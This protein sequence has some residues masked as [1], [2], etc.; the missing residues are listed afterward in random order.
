MKQLNYVNSRP[1]GFEHE[2]IVNIPLFSENMN[3]IFRQSDSTYLNRLQIFRNAVEGQ[4]GVMSTALSS[5]APGV[6]VTYRGVVPEGF[7]RRIISLSPIQLLTMISSR[8]MM[9]ALVAGRAFSKDFGTDA[10]EGFMVNETAVRDF[11]WGTPE[12]ALGKTLTREGKKGHVIGVIRDFN[13]SSLTTAITPMVLE[14]EP[15]QLNTL[16]VR[17]DNPDVKESIEKLEASW[18]KIFPEKSFEFT[19]LD[20]QL[21]EQYENFQNFG[22]VIQS[23]TLIAILISCLG[24]YGLVLFV[25]QRKVKE[26]GVR[27]VLGAS[28]GNI[29]TLIYKDFAWLLAIG[30]VLAVPVSYYL[31]NRWLENFIYHTTLDVLTYTIS[32][33]LVVTIVLIT[34]SY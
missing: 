3:G 26:I 15:N 21:A 12:Q 27:K 20:E 8:P 6:G 29:L 25:V 11:N 34:I 16:S 31:M 17:F 5:Y 13:F 9:S 18:N 10:A 33:V 32:F 30:F 22:V 4:S 19:F 23:F 14:I 2:H 24:V 7:T 1:L 28:T